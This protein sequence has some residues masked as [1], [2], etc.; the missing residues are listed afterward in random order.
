MNEDEKKCP[1]CAETV[2]AEAKVCRHCGYDFVTGQGPGTT[3]HP[4]PPE[5]SSTVKKGA[6]G[7]LAIV[8]I[9][10]ILGMIVGGGEQGAGGGSSASNEAAIQVSAQEL[11]AAYDANEAAAQQ[12]YGGRRLEVTGTVNAIQLDVSNKPFLVLEGTNMFM[13]PQAHLTASAQ[14]QAASISRGQDIRLSCTDVG[15]IIGTPM[16]RNCD[17]LE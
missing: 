6:L 5:K 7:C 11:A 2:K 17:I 3:A 9:L 4:I 10:V 14:D 12:Q 15:E 16:L 8:V 1:R 13:G